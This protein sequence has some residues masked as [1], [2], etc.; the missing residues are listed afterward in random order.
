MPDETNKALLKAAYDKGFKDALDHR[1]MYVNFGEE[2]EMPLEWEGYTDAHEREAIA[3]I[4]STVEWQECFR[5]NMIRQAMLKWRQAR[6]NMGNP[7]AVALSFAVGNAIMDLI[8]LY[9]HAPEIEEPQVNENA[10]GF[11]SS[12]SDE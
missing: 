10:N 12:F 9:S 6:L 4:V 3:S 2:L 11:D 7:Q 1:R 8:D 5:Q